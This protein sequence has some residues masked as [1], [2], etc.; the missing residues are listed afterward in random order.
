MPNTA[1]DTQTPAIG[2]GDLL[3][4]KETA[5]LLGVAI[6]TLRNWRCTSNGPRFHKVGARMVRYRRADLVAFIGESLGGPL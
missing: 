2:P 3:D 4:E 6:R 5:A 1:P